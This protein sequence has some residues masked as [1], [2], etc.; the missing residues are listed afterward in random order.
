MISYSRSFRTRLLASGIALSLIAGSGAI[1]MPSQAEVID[2]MA[3]EHAMIDLSQV[4]LSINSGDAMEGEDYRSY[5]RDYQDTA[6][7]LINKFEV[8]KNQLTLVSKK[9]LEFEEETKKKLSTYTAI[10]KQFEERKAYYTLLKDAITKS[11]KGIKNSNN[12][13]LYVQGHTENAP[14]WFELVVLEDSTFYLYHTTSTLRLPVAYFDDTGFATV[15]HSNDITEPKM[16]SGT[17]ESIYVGAMNADLE[18]DGNGILYVE[19]ESINAGKWVKDKLSGY[20]YIYNGV[21]QASNVIQF[22]DGIK[23]GMA[24]FATKNSEDLSTRIYLNGQLQGMSFSEY[25]YDDYTAQVMNIYQDDEALPITY[26]HYPNSGDTRLIFEQPT[27]EKI[28]LYDSE[29]YERVFIG[30]FKTGSLSGFGYGLIENIEYIGSFDK[31]NILGDGTFFKLNEE[32]SVFNDR[33]EKVLGE[34]IKDNMTEKEKIKAVHDYLV[35]RI[36]YN[37]PDAKVE[38]QPGYTHTAY[39]A[40]IYGSAVCDGYAQ[41]FKV[42][43]DQ[44]DIENHMIYGIT[45]DRDGTFKETNRHAWNIVKVDDEFLH[46]DLTW[47]DPTFQD[48]IDHTYYFM[49]S[50][51]IKKDHKW[52]EEDYA[53]YLGEDK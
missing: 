13:T 52:V 24:I 3:P 44:L 36:N 29:K 25:V 4:F 45:A 17:N 27:G 34:I 47:N 11:S 40:L 39:G 12:E 9:L 42:M 48:T 20:T 1:S 43:L 46:F 10:S 28:E 2:G 15:K 49:S 5:F 53:E 6:D 16:M 37:K 32:E 30:D 38:N 51:K 50:K 31:F 22:K 18:K 21:D 33:V 23:H 41:S 7:V 26:V 35:D 14:W 19:D 8:S